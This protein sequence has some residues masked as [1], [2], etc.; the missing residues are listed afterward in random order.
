MLGFDRLAQACRSERI[1]DTT[2]TCQ[3]MITAK[4]LIDW[5]V[6]QLLGRQQMFVIRCDTTVVRCLIDWYGWHV[7]IWDNSYLCNNCLLLDVIQLFGLT[8]LLD[9]QQPHNGWWIDL[10]KLGFLLCQ[11]P[12]RVT[13]TCQLCQ[14]A[15]ANFFPASANFLAKQ[16]KSCATMSIL[17]IAL[18][19]INVAI[20]LIS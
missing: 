19:P 16:A 4:C 6:W 9:V 2:V 10:F 20:S 12:C 8:Q 1:C 17:L 7:N 5:H 13:K 15:S 3:V 18:A 11:L 14:P